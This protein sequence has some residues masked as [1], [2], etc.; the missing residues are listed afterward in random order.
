MS[1]DYRGM[2]SPISLF[3]RRGLLRLCRAPCLSAAVE[4]ERTG[5][6]LK[7]PGEPNQAL[8]PTIYPWFW[9][10]TPYGRDCRRNQ[11][12]ACACVF[13]WSL[14]AFIMK[15]KHNGSKNRI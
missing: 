4:T 14:K 6:C 1:F 9:I 5:A 11:N 13:S 7:G 8:S 12:F 2:C 3:I 10:D 15:T